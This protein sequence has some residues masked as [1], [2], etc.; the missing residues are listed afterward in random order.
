[1][2]RAKGKKINRKRDVG[3]ARDRVLGWVLI[4]NRMSR[5]GLIEVTLNQR[6]KRGD[7]FSHVYLGN[8]KHRKNNQCKGI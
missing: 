5:I 8:A 4:L 1:M 2:I 3:N 6:L 7:E